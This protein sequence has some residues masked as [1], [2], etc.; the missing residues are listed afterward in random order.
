MPFSECTC[1]HAQPDLGCVQTESSAVKKTF[2][3]ASLNPIK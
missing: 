1:Q 2:R 3:G